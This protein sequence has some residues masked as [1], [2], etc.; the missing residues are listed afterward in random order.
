MYIEYVYVCVF[1]WVVL[2]FYHAGRKKGEG[3]S[4]Y[5]CFSENLCF[6]SLPFILAIKK[7]IHMCIYMYILTCIF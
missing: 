5:S 1:S 2:H 6:Y 7:C 3:L 4:L